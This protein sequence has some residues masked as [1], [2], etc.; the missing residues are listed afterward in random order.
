M[1]Q[2]Q[3]H[4][5]WLHYRVADHM[6]I[7]IW[8]YGLILLAFYGLGA[9]LYYFHTV[10][11]RNPLHVWAVIVNALIAVFIVL[12]EAEQ[13]GKPMLVWRLP[14]QTALIL[15]VWWSIQIA[16]RSRSRGVEL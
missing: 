12:Q 15:A 14:Y 8:R 6:I 1:P 10:K 13:V 16:R 11:E 3:I 4:W 5:G 2:G 9:A 7:D